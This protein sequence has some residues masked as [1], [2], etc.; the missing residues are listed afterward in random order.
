MKLSVEEVRTGRTG[1]GRRLPVGAASTGAA[2]ALWSVVRL[3]VRT[4]FVSQAVWIDALCASVIL[5]GCVFLGTCWFLD[6][7]WLLC[8]VCLFGVLFLQNKETTCSAT[9]SPC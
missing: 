7:R 9:P 5:L 1:L 2:L 4:A 3:I 6:I 8:A